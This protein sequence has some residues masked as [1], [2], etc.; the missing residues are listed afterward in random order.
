MLLYFVCS[1]V[2]RVPASAI[3]ATHRA[4]EAHRSTGPRVQDFVIKP[5]G[6][7]N[8]HIDV[9]IPNQEN[10]SVYHIRVSV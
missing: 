2:I 7:P 8:K 10:V 1:K 9:E 4:S 5:I 3:R 6:I